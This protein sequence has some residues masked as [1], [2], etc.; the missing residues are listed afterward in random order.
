MATFR[1]ENKG[2]KKAIIGYER[3]SRAMRKP[4]YV[5]EVDVGPGKGRTKK[6]N[7][8]IAEVQAGHRPGARRKAAFPGGGTVAGVLPAKR[9]KRDPWFLDKSEQ[10][11]LR[12]ILETF[13]KKFEDGQHLAIVNGMRRIG[14]QMK[15]F[16]KSHIDEQR[17]ENG[18]FNPDLSKAYKRYKKR[19]WNKVYPILRASDTLY[20][21][22]RW[23]YNGRKHKVGR[24]RRR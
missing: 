15:R 2:L 6:K 10:R 8:M 9:L 5:V 24:K 14:A 18:K 21:S 16:I 1:M 7:V 13:I 23:G 19:K 17:N 11:Q 4:H 20:E 3:K 12:D 22:I